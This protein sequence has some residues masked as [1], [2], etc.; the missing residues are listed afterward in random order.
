MLKRVANYNLAGVNIPGQTAKLKYMCEKHW[1]NYTFNQLNVLGDN[2]GLRC[3]VGY[4]VLGG[5]VG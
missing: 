5:S 4:Q 1:K 2:Q 3:P